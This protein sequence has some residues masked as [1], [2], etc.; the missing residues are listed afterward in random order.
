MLGPQTSIFSWRR[1]KIKHLCDFRQSA[2]ALH[3]AADH[4]AVCEY[5]SAWSGTLINR[6]DHYMLLCV[7]APAPPVFRTYKGNLWFRMHSSTL[8]IH[9]PKEQ[10]RILFDDV[11]MISGHDAS[12][13]DVLHLLAPLVPSNARLFRVYRHIRNVRKQILHIPRSKS[14]NSL[15]TR[16]QY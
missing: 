5:I 4:G 13:C 15:V 10:I 8:C 14:Q 1:K 11:D 7:A 9:C 3:W 16:I 12:R 2:V 6:R